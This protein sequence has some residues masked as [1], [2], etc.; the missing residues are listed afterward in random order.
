[1]VTKM[2]EIIFAE[3]PTLGIRKYFI[4]RI[5]LKRTTLTVRTKYGQIR[6]KES[7]YG[8]V[9][10]RTPE[11]DDCRKAAEKYGVPIRQVISEAQKR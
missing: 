6:I 2:E 8:D 1:M 4:S 9:I 10:N 11:Y 3:I 7:R 5:K